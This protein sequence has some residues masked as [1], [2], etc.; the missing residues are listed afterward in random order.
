MFRTYRSMCIHLLK[1]SSG[2]MVVRFSR[3]RIHKQGENLKLASKVWNKCSQ[4]LMGWG[5]PE[6]NTYCDHWIQCQTACEDHENHLRHHLHRHRGHAR[7]HHQVRHP[8]SYQSRVLSCSCLF[9]PPRWPKVQW[10]GSVF[11]NLS[12]SNKCKVSS[13]LFSFYYLL[14]TLWERRLWWSSQQLER[15]Q[16]LC[17]VAI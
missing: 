10:L 12:T 13:W 5:S 1:Q 16:R 15:S 11:S 7:H 14:R 9:F 3:S 4:W 6:K 8:I 2:R 17:S